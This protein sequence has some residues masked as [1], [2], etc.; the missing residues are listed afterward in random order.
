MKKLI[1][2]L[3][4]L[5]VFFANAQVKIP[6]TSDYVWQD[7]S[8][9]DR[10]DKLV[11]GDTTSNYAPKPPIIYPQH[12]VVFDLWA[13]NATVSSVKMFIAFP[14]TCTVHVIVERKS[15]Y[16]Q[17]EIGTFSGGSFQNFTYTNSDPAQ[18]SKVILRTTSKNYQFGSEVELYGTYSSP[19]VVPHKVKRPLGWMTGA[20]AQSYDLM[21]DAKLN[22]VKS[23]GV[24]EGSLRVWEY[25]EDVTDASN[26]W[27][28]EKEMGTDRYSI[29]S[30]F[31]LLKSWSPNLYT[32]KVISHQFT[33][34]KISWDVIDDF[35][36]KYIRGTVTSYV[37]HGSW[38]EIFMNI[39]EVAGAVGDTYVPA[40]HVYKGGVLINVTET[41]EIFGTSLVGQSR[42]YN[43]GGSL[44]LSVGDVLYFYKSQRSVN[45]IFWA[46][47]GLSRRDTDSAHIYSGQNAFVYAGRGGKNPSVP[48]YPIQSG[49]RMLKGYGIYN[50][51]EMANEPN[52]WWG[53]GKDAFWNGKTVFYHMNMVYD[54][55]K[56]QFANTGA[57]QADS[58]ID[59]LMDGM[60]TG[61]SDQIW[62]AINEAR[63]HRGYLPDGSVNVP[64]DAVNVHLYPSAEGQYGW[65]TLGGFPPEIGMRAFLKGFLDL[66]E[67]FCPQVKLYVSEWGWDQHPGSPLHAGVFG[68]YDRE[69]VGSFWM[70]RAMLQMAAMGVDRSTYYPLFQDWPESASSTD[71]TL[72]KTMRLL[73]QP[74]DADP[75]Y[76]VRSRQGD[77]MA[78]YNEF[79][80]FVYSDSVSTGNPWLHAYK[81]KK[82]G[83]DSAILAVWS[84]EVLSIV[85][86]TTSFVE[87]TGNINLSIPVGSYKTRT[88]KDDGSAAMASTTNTSTGTVTVAYAAKPVIL[89]YVDAATNQ[90]PTANAGVDQSITLPTSTVTLSGSG[91]DPDGTIASYTWTKISGSGTITS[92][93]TAS[94]TITSLTTGTNVYRLTVTDN[95]GATAFDDVVI[96][97]NPAPN[98]PPSANAG[99]DQTITLP[100][101]TTTLSG[102]GLDTDGTIVSYTWTKISGSGTI[103]STTTSSTLVTSLPIGI[104]KF[105][106]TVTDNN[107][108]TATDDV[109]IVVNAAPNVAP[110]ANA[111]ID[112]TITLP[113]STVTLTGSGADTDGTIVSY[114]WAKL[115]GSGTIT[116]SS[117]AS[118]TVTSL[119]AGT[120]TFRLTVT[121][122]SGATATDDIQVVVNAAP[123]V[124]QSPIADAGLNQV[125]V[126]PTSVV[127]LSGTGS[128]PDG[129]VVSYSWTK[130][131]GSGVIT[132]TNYPSTTVTSLTTGTST[133]RLA[134]TDDKGA[135]ATDDVQVIVNPAVLS[136]NVFT[137]Q[138]ISNTGLLQ[139]TQYGYTIVQRSKDGYSFKSL[140]AFNGTSYVDSHPF[141]GM[142]FYRIQTPSGYSEVKMLFFGKQYMQVTVYDTL[143]RRMFQTSTNDLN[144]VKTQIQ[145]STLPPGTY[146]IRN[147]G[148][149]WTEKVIKF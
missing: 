146:L 83:T 138:K 131:S 8:Q 37:D 49:Q 97:V 77:Y 58:T 80:H 100:T 35:P 34:Q 123:A 121:D 104:H 86:D 113:T 130:I 29:D 38:G 126:L 42:H 91:T 108:A 60:A 22:A 114:S 78:Q 47:N 19:S 66:I 30:A 2:L 52:A 27:K 18:V 129:T 73:R 13:W 95:A 111:G 40:W 76:I 115:S 46:D 84:E 33:P 85:S 1:F 132:S 61:F 145:N 101:S 149:N 3:S 109:Q 124:N 5:S 55:N 140:A 11:D 68:S 116:S 75:T 14:D 127:T 119:G 31:V 96:T 120:S 106:L 26:N 134:V 24:S 79:K 50:A 133:F 7:N 32:W 122:N 93:G 141:N 21:N 6:I 74:I 17:T 81:Y 117:A 72:F 110:T 45:P 112:Q 44:G 90:S 20:V 9:Q 59:V 107:G 82:P 102:S 118:T 135:T 23:L 25:G 53:Q 65:G 89:Q 137:A 43:V 125:I 136:T 16:H 36:N 63:I 87:R 142:N 88:F 92:A 67:R 15:D 98:V 51:V 70:V 94:T 143:G 41:P 56:K 71:A 139:W 57:K 128:D 62:G 64:F 99:T 147:D 103:T 69:T 39:A 48:N 28:F 144:L 105:R 4:F 148:N 10:A 12:E 54:G